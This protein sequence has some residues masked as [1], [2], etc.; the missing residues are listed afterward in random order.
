MYLACLQWQN[1]TAKLQIDF[2]ALLL[3]YT[4]SEERLNSAT[5]ARYAVMS[6]FDVRLM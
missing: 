3:K 2:D 4:F 5:Q 6:G 1:R